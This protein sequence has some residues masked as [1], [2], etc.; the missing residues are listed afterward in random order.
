MISDKHKCIFIHVPKCAGESIEAVFLGGPFNTSTYG[1]HPEKHWGVKEISKIYPKCYTSYFSF[2]IIR[3]PWE[4]VLSWVKYRDKRWGRTTG[5]FE[6]RLWEDLNDAKFVHY[7]IN[8]SCA[9]LLYL[10]GRI[11]VDCV[12]R[13]EN[14]KEGF[15]G[16]CDV[17]GMGKIQLPHRNN[18]E[19]D[20]YTTYFNDKSRKRVAELFADDIRLFNYKFE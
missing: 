10:D 15:N 18:T 6:N 8:H 19:H 5:K 9:N 20:F 16:I 14:L 13:M 11:G 12:I 4:R 1:G 2:S 7:M 17:L 3:N